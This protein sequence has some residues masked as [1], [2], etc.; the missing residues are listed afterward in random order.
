MRVVF[1]AILASLMAVAMLWFSGCV[2]KQE[3]ALDETQTLILDCVA[4]DGQIVVG[5]DG[6]L[7][8]L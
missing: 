8:C 1:L 3:R 7:I 2:T 6:Q 5:A 4:R